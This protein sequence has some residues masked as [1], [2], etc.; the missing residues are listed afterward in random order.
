MP[1]NSYTVSDRIL[2]RLA[3][4]TSLI[5]R[6]SFDLETTLVASGESHPEQKHIFICGLARAGTTVLM[7]S[8]YDSGKLCSL[9]YRNMPFVLMPNLW[10]KLSGRFRM[11]GQVEERAHGDGLFVDFDSPEAFEE[12]FWLTFC[13]DQYVFDDSLKPHDVS[14]AN[15]DRFR[16]YIDCILASSDALGQAYLSKNNNNILRIHAI[17][18]AFPASLILIP[19]R[20]PLTQALSLLTQHRRFI[21][22]HTADKFTREYMSWLGHYE[23]GAGHK[24]FLFG[25]AFGN[26]ECEYQTSDI[27]YWL[28]LWIRTY[29]YLLQQARGTGSIFVCYEKL[30]ES[31]EAVLSHLFA[32]AGIHYESTVAD[33]IHSKSGADNI[34]GVDTML[35]QRAEA[36][37]Q[38]LLAADVLPPGVGDS[39]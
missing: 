37:Y 2:H 27:N 24:P 15:I 23:F 12:V 35:K 30:C 16:D 31:P 20:D 6:A 21:A 36:I 17:R 11:Q 28:A 4:S 10:K 5:R 26:I 19:F 8:F 22:L 39:L 34:I 18:R 9:T 13:G 1:S 38:C 33:T 7:R 14:A 32:S 29:D 3:L 25:Q